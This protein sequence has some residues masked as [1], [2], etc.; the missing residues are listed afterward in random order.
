[1]LHERKLGT[2][3]GPI[4]LRDTRGTQDLR[5]FVW[6]GPLDGAGDG[7]A[8]V[9]HDAACMLLVEKHNVFERLRMDGFAQERRCVVLCGNGYL[10]RSFHRLVHRIHEQLQVPLYVLADNDPAGYEFFFHVAR[11]S[12]SARGRPQ[13]ATAIPIAAFLGLRVRDFELLGLSDHVGIDLS[14][15]E[16]SQIRR[17]MSCP[18]LRSDAAW[19]Q[20]LDGLMQ[21]GFKV[22]L[23]AL[24]TIS[25]SHMASSYLPDRL[26][27]SDH[28]LNPTR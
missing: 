26:D 4:V 23:E 28:L 15:P 1:M 25:L 20:E 21:R 2:I 10:G 7:V 5:C 11:G 27:A 16:R 13:S 9:E 24:C 12:A 19:Q 8:V 22:E 14:D 17:L 18:W 3:V 6:R